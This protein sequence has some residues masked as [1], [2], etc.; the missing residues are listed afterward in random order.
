[1][2][3]QSRDRDPIGE[4]LVVDDVPEN[5]AAIETALSGLSDA[6]VFASS[7]EEALRRVSD[8]DFALVLLDEHTAAG[9]LATARRIRRRT[10]DLPIIFIT[11]EDSDAD[12]LLAGCHLGAV[13]F[14]FEPINPELLRAKVAVFVELQR[15]AA[16]I[17]ELEHDNQRLR[18]ADRRKDKF[19]AML[20][21]ELR[22]PLAVVTAAVE[23]LA[24]E[25]RSN[26]VRKVRPAL[27]RKVT[28]LTRLVDDLTDIARI[29]S[30]KLRL[31]PELIPV[32]DLISEAVE[33][34]SPAI[35]EKHH[36][37]QIDCRCGDLRL[38][39]DRVRLAQVLGNLLANAARYTAAGGHLRVSA[40]LDERGDLRLRVA[41]DGRGMTP[42]LLSR[43]F[44][45]FVRGDETHDGLGIG[46]TLVQTLTRMHGGEVIARSDG[47]GRGSEFELRLPVAAPERRGCAAAA[48][49]D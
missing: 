7:S 1:M 9:G 3:V 41:D 21:H 20:A 36:A 4:I 29:T 38:F 46:L 32:D 30:G 5:L 34:A 48:G 27:A 11:A 45:P 6:L 42:A 25:S 35:V 44:K 23:L 33:L 22:S 43:V 19:I 24:T 14:L 2:Q 10:Q 39:G 37:L 40:W 26:V 16:L 12:E 15:R 31:D 17:N 18:A 49:R 13:D 8:R 47:P 28:H